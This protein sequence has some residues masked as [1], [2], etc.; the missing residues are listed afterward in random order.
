MERD[1]QTSTKIV[2]ELVNSILDLNVLLESI[3]SVV[4]DGAPNWSDKNRLNQS[5]K[6]YRDTLLQKLLSKVIGGYQYQDK[7]IDYSYFEGWVKDV[8]PDLG[9]NRNEWLPKD[10][11]LLEIMGIVWLKDNWCF[12]NNYNDNSRSE[13]KVK[14]IRL[15]YGG[16]H[17]EYL[18]YALDFVRQDS[19]EGLMEIAPY[20]KENIKIPLM[21][22]VV[23][24]D[25]INKIEKAMG[26]VVVSSNNI[27]NWAYLSNSGWSQTSE[28]WAETLNGLIKKSDDGV[29]K[30]IKGL[31]YF[32]SD[33]LATEKLTSR[34]VEWLKTDTGIRSAKFCGTYIL[35]KYLKSRPFYYLEMLMEAK[36]WFADAINNLDEN[37]ESWLNEIPAAKKLA[38]R[39]DK[40]VMDR[41]IDSP[42]K[43]NDDVLKI[44]IRGLIE[45]GS[46]K[47]RDIVNAAF[48]DISLMFFKKDEAKI[49]S[50][51]LFEI[52]SSQ[53]DKYKILDGVNLESTAYKRFSEQF[54]KIKMRGS[55]ASKN[56]NERDRNDLYKVFLKW[57]IL[58]TNEKGL[59]CF[60]GSRN[61]IVR[62]KT[63]GYIEKE[64]DS[65]EKL[66]EF[67]LFAEKSG[68]TGVSTTQNYSPFL[69]ETFKESF[70]EAIVCIER[71]LLTKDLDVAQKMVRKSI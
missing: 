48:S 6:E 69:S 58:K 70:E 47:N 14:I 60:Y 43:I 63:L 49:M 7:K 1:Q 13:E 26:G 10:D 37:G 19:A 61:E 44:Y 52:E 38:Y 56:Q 25:T 3:R 36:E 15:F 50:T 16:H 31:K 41:W 64:V 71:K 34:I 68:I 22:E 4:K 17:T 12:K 24:L 51:F 9:K 11:D 40:G 65:L 45:C 30:A 62:S 42:Y 54:L 46:E 53:I 18:R 33:G 59:K 27:I 5:E 20:V 21:S 67:K 55:S 66:R 28:K 39:V 8:L 2:K 57:A 29:D 35:K 23:S 32:L